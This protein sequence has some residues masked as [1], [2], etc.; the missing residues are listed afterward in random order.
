MFV[1]FLKKEASNADVVTLGDYWGREQAV[2]LYAQY[3]AISISKV[4]GQPVL[5]LWVLCQLSSIFR[6]SVGVRDPAEM[7]ALAAF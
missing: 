6:E 7:C 2:L 1:C 3:T 4:K 5:T